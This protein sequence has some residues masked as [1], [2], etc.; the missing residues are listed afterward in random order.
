LDF[1]TTK[2][3]EIGTGLQVGIFHN[4]IFFGYGVNLHMLSPKQYPFYYFIGFSFAK[5]SDFFTSTKNV[6]AVQ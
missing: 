4:K 3:V 2:D 1:S 6:N 5:L